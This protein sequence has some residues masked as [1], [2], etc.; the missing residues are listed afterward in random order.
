MVKR[1]VLLA[2][3]ILV[4]L[5][6]GFAQEVSERKEIAIF[7]LGHRGWSLPQ[8]VLTSIDQELLSVFINLGRFDVL[9]ITQRLSQ[10]DVTEF[11]ERI[12]EFKQEDVEIPEEFQMGQE[13]FTE[14]DMNRLIGSFIVVIPAVTFF[15]VERKERELVTGETDVT[16]EAQLKTSFTFINVAE[17]ET[18]AQFFVETEA[19]ED[20]RNEAIQNAVDNIPLRLEF[21]ITKIP[22]FTIKTGVLERSGSEVVLELGRDL[23]I[24]KGY[25]FAVVSTQI[26]ESGRRFDTEEG[27]LVIKDVGDEVSLAKIIFGDPA[28]GDQLKEVPRLGFEATPYLHVLTRTDSVFF[29]QAGVRAVASKGFYEFRPLAGIE[30][31]IPIGGEGTLINAMWVL[32]FPF[33]FYLGGGGSSKRKNPLLPIWGAM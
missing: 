16:F 4:T 31:P 24:R 19:S 12:K 15:N 32:G 7:R 13:I 20:S 30:V 29:S 17:V 14:R 2:L 9:G 10:D 33:S 23:G 3:L 25:E 21:E 8:G 6:L 18:F 11:I 26:L 1:L 22:E 27:L 28:V 5:N